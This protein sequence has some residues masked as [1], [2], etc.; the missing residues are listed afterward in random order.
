M[1]CFSFFSTLHE[2]TQFP[3][4]Q[5]TTDKLIYYLISLNPSEL[6]YQNKFNPYNI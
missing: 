3:L 6:L 4:E 5:T 2:H 1:D